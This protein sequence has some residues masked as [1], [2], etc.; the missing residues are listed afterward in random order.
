MCCVRDGELPPIDQCA[1]HDAHS[2]QNARASGG[3]RAKHL[4]NSV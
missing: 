2:S 4:V 1:V 3:K